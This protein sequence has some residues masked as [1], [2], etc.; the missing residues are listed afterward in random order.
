MRR[1]LLL[2]S[3]VAVPSGAQ[4]VLDTHK[5]LLEEDRRA[6]QVKRSAAE[7]SRAD[8]ARPAER[9]RDPRACESARVYVQAA[10]GAPYSA[11]SRTRLCA[12][13]GVLYR[14]NC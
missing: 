10:C 3:F 8:L 7:E 14:Q 2:L 6:N 5:R 13:A 12:E 1:F 9:V 4:E 11:R